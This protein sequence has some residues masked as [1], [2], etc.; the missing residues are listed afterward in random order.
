MHQVTKSRRSLNT[1]ILPRGVKE[2]LLD[3]ARDFLASEEWYTWAGVPH[4][5]GKPN[6]TLRLR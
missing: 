2:A 4:R 5:R 1:L 3:D 6:I